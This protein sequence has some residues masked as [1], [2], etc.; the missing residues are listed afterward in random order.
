[1]ITPITRQYQSRRGDVWEGETFRLISDQGASY[2]TNPVVRSQIRINP[3]SPQVIHQFVITP[4]I[5]TEGTNGVLTFQINLSEAESLGINPSFYVG[6]IDV[7]SDNFPR[8]TICTYT[9]QQL[10]DITR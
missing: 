1:M 10:I 3:N 7:R 2:W 6:D 8:S 4:V 5:T 9:F